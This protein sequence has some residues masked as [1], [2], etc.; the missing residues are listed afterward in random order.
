MYST[1]NINLPYLAPAQAQKHV[2]VNESLAELDC[3][4]QLAVEAMG[5]DTPPATATDGK[6]YLIGANPSGDWAREAGRL[7]S[8]RNGGWAFSAPQP[9]W[10]VYNLADDTLYVRT[11]AG[12]WRAISGAGAA[13]TE[14]QNA[15]RLGVGMAADAANP[16]SAKLN[17]A[18]FT[19]RPAEEGGSGDVYVTANKSTAADDAGFAFQTNFVTRAIAGLFGSNRFRIAVSPD[20]AAFQDALRID[21]ATGVVD[22]PRTPR[23]KAH[24]NFDN[25]GAIDQWIRIGINTVES[26]DLGAFDPA[27]NRFT[28]PAAG[29]YLFGATLLY[30]INTNSA[31]RMRARLMLNGASEIRGAYGEISGAHFTLATTL[32]I[33]TVAALAQ[34]DRVELQGSF[35]GADAYF[36]ANTTSFWGFKVG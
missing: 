15:T 6:R 9:G 17:S 3:L 24:T 35:R 14:L 16:L 30:R 33:Q 23:F 26:N 12:T 34:G 10:R 19:A 36:A 13:P 25:Y 2:T 7:A 11:T 22:L 5:V 27:L 32:T 20:G 8:W 18:L 1:P 28:A 21:D 29:L 4:V 31:A